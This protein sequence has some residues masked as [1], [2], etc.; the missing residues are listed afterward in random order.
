MKYMIKQ[1][2]GGRFQAGVSGN[3]RFSLRNWL[4]LAAGA[5]GL[6]AAGSGQ[7]QPFSLPFY[8]PFPTSANTAYNGLAYANNE[9]LGT[10]GSGAS[11]TLWT[12]GNSDT[13]SSP[14]C[15][16]TNGQ[17]GLEYPGLTNVD[18]TYETGLLST[19]NRDS[20]STKNRAVPLIIP[21]NNE[22]APMAVYASFLLDIAT[23]EFTPANNPT[24]FFGLVT[25]TGGSSV[26]VQGA[27]VY[28]NTSFQL[29]LSKNQTGAP[30]AAATN[31]TP[32]LVTNTTHLIVLRYQYAG[33]GTNDSVDL[34]VDPIALG[35]NATVPAPT[36]SITNGGNLSSN[37]FGGVA[38]FEYV[39][40][41]L[42]YIDEI[43][44]ATNWGGVTPSNSWSGKIYT[45]SG[46]GHGCGS[47]TFAINLS[48]SD[49][50]VT[51]WVYTN[52]VSTGVSATPGAS[53]STVSL[54]TF[55]GLATYTVVGSNNAAAPSI[56]TT[57]M[58]GGAT[59]DVYQPVTITTEPSN[60]TVPSGELGG[61]SVGYTGTGVTFQWYS[62]GV[63]LVNGNEFSGVN[64]S[65][66][67]I[68]PVGSQDVLSGTHGYYCVL[69]D[70]CGNPA[71][72]TTNSLT[73]GS[74]ANL[75]WVGDGN[76]DLWDV[77]TSPN[78][79]TTDGGVANTVFHYGDN[80][81]FDDSSGNT[82]VTL[83][84][85]YLSPSTI[86]VNGANNNYVFSG[87]G[88]LAGDG[89]L[90]INSTANPGLTFN[91]GVVNTETSGIT[92][93]SG[94]TL[95][96]DEAGNLG[97][98]TITLAGGQ[99]AGG[100]VGQVVADNV[101]N[102]TAANSII[103][104]NA[105]G[106]QGLVLTNNIQ[107]TSGNLTFINNTT[108]NVGTASVILQY[109]AIAFNLPVDLNPGPNGGSVIL[110]GE[111][112]N[113]VQEWQN[114]ITDAGEIQRNGAGGETLLDNAN[115]TYSGGTLL[116]S[117]ALGVANNSVG[118]PGSLVSG[119]LGIGSLIIDTAAGASPQIFASGGAWNVANPVT[120]FSN[121]LGNPWVISGSDELT[122]GGTVDLNANLA[123]QPFNLTGTNRAIV[124]S[125]TV[126]A[127]FT[128]VISDDG[129]DM[130]ISVSGTGALYLDGANTY[131]GTTTNDASLL[132]GTGSVAGSV[133][134]NSDG[135]LGAGS[136]S[137]IGTFSISGN[138]SLAGDLF[139]RVNKSLSPSL[140]NDTIVVTG[141]LNNSGTGTV[142]VDNLGPAL[143]VGNQFALFNKAIAGGG[144]LTISGGGVG[145][146]QNNLA[147]NGTIKVLT[148]LTPPS[149]V[150]NAVSAGAGNL[151]FSGTNGTAGNPY[152]VLTTT[153]LD[154]PWTTNT[155]GTFGSGGTFSVSVPITNSS[156]AARFFKLQVP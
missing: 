41:P 96:F 10:A 134:V 55:G 85:P 13:S 37:F 49:A 105:P 39:N 117:G 62:N 18:A 51:Y 101:I 143:A 114:V 25:N 23:N 97:T 38:I 107:G 24:P 14:R 31:V 132:A 11:G 133:V 129:N 47:Q 70:T 64:T 151:N 29:Q 15:F 35:S 121:L 7:A 90:V 20:S 59:I 26:N 66:L 65:N 17:S 78:W 19:Y 81:T 137:V 153:N 56:A 118:S 108:K 84:N 147:V 135:T 79:S 104:V 120:W 91:V 144:A 54:G 116:T 69:S 32:A 30:P 146:W 48:G 130:G 16:G 83:N 141:S 94:A 138:L 42:I 22:S 102:V 111:N 46:G 152:A 106:G 53:S 75:F 34:W 139:I 6:L 110:A 28:M 115:N 99:L 93:N 71:T 148:L 128:N 82:A 43:R 52:G 1:Q 50:G 86:T 80:V 112:T 149:P 113:G 67:V 150:I 3:N 154:S 109:P 98:G 125:N 103:G 72:S 63:A 36:I 123:A 87:P 156:P 124:V 142:T 33:S 73:L 127:V 122:F 92:I 8:E 89:S 61:F 4:L 76:L 140:S 131:T 88:G 74:P 60:L 21:T 68:F 45:I 58:S 5:I 44:V 2:Q 77:D 136:P 145:S 9:E 27:L 126:S 119:P 40:P 57:W 100:D 95:V 155:T 12:F